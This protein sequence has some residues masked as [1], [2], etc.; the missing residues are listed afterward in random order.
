MNNIREKHTEEGIA[1][2]TNCIKCHKGADENEIQIN[3]SE[4]KK[5]I[6]KESKHNKNDDD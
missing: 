6:N 5:Y 2:F 3:E 4:V 1:N